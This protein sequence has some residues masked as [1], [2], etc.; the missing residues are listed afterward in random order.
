MIKQVAISA[1][2][3]LAVLFLVGKVP[4]VRRIVGI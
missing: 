1:V 2:V 3:T 4:A